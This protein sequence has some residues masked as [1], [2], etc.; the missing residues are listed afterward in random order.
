MSVILFYKCNSSDQQVQFKVYLSYS[1]TAM[2][3]VVEVRRISLNIGF[4]V[5]SDTNDDNPV[6]NTYNLNVQPIVQRILK[7][8]GWDIK[9]LHT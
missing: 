9:L 5:S 7:L 6:D 1:A 4:F 3:D 2:L 8:T